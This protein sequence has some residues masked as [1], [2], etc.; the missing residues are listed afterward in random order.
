M[1]P[2][3]KKI[4][5]VVS[6]LLAIVFAALAIRMN[7]ADTKESCSPESVASIIPFFT[8]T[9]AGSILLWAASFQFPRLRE[10]LAFLALLLLIWPMGSLNSFI[11]C[12]ESYGN[13]P[14]WAAG[15]LIVGFLSY[16]LLFVSRAAYASLVSI[17]LVIYMFIFS[18]N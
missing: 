9:T 4:F 15:A 16:S 12:H 1:G 17:G 10:W 3:S 7:L 13:V 18:S 6:T 14:V 8:Y 11:C 2:V 5:F